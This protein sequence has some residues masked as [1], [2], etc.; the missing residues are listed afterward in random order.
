MTKRRF[1][2]VP[3]KSDSSGKSD[4]TDESVS[5]DDCCADGQCTCAADGGSSSPSQLRSDGGSTPSNVDTDGSLGD[6]QFTEPTVGESQDVEGPDANPTVRPGVPEKVNL[7]TPG[8]S[9]RSEMNDIDT[10]DEKT[11]FMEL[12]EAVIEE[13]RCIQCGTCVAACPSDS[14]GIGDDGLPELGKDVHRLFALLGF[15]PAGRTP[16]RTTVENHR[17]R[18]QRVWCRRPHHRVLGKSHR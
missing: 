13:E 11:W 5:P 2:G 15:L 14:I 1:P 17:R 4:S 12:D 7:D 3:G 9:I 8:Y 6:I 10:P 18:R 16:I